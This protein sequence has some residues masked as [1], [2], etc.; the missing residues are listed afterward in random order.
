MKESQ[1]RDLSPGQ[2]LWYWVHELPNRLVCSDFG[3][4]WVSC[5]VIK[6]N[7]KSVNILVRDR[8]GGGDEFVHDIE[9]HKRAQLKSLRTTKPKNGYN[10]P[11]I[12]DYFPEI[13]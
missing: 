7:K 3:G 1:L 6:I 9:C 8:V 4:Y 10:D 2:K 5:K 11:E 13:G 12:K